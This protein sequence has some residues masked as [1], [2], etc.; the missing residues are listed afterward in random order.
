MVSPDHESL[1][2]RVVESDLLGDVLMEDL[3]DPVHKARWQA[4]ARAN[5]VLAREVL[6]RIH[7]ASR[8]N[9]DIQKKMIDE[10][11]YVYAALAA[12]ALR[13][14]SQEQ[15]PVNVGDDA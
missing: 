14:S 7:A 2:P 3:T 13:L 8:A 6:M 15:T 5:G 10:I 11:T 9:P 4:F 1:L 12:A